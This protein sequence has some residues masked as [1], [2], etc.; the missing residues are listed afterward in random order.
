MA[1]RT[2]NRQPVSILKAPPI[3]IGFI[4]SAFVSLKCVPRLVMGA[5]LLSVAAGGQPA[6]MAES[7]YGNGGIGGTGEAFEAALSLR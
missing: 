1:V 5:F 7:W 4:S 2:V 3:T 6:S